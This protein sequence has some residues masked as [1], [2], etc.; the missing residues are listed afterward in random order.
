MHILFTWFLFYSYKFWNMGI[1]GNKDSLFTWNFK[2]VLDRFSWNFRFGPDA[3]TLHYSQVEA[4]WYVVL[5][6]WKTTKY[7]C[8][9]FG[10]YLHLKNCF[11]L[12]HRTK[13]QWCHV[14]FNIFQIFCHF[15]NFMNVLFCTNKGQIQPNMVSL[16]INIKLIS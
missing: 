15:Y 14:V 10:V 11:D 7:K 13:K 4:V 12:F 1:Q 9:T 5:L 8:F 16:Y 2:L 3:C 6:I